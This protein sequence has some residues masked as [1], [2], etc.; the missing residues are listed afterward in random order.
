MPI[1][2]IAQQ[3]TEPRMLFLLSKDLA[4]LDLKEGVLRVHFNYHAQL[5]PEI[6]F[7]VLRELRLRAI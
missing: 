7:K 4:N 5:D 6:V 2:V 3:W 1:A